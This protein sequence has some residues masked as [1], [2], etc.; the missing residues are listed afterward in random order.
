MVK[1]NNL[2]IIVIFIVYVFINNFF[3]NINLLITKSYEERVNKIYNVACGGFSYGFVKKVLDNYL[4]NNR[5]LYIH[6]FENFP[7]NYSLFLNIEFD[8]NIKNLILLNYKK[9]NTLPVHI[10][11]DNYLL[12]Y[13]LGNCYY[14]IKK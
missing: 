12:K 2:L 3:I 7:R 6:N 1:K 10:N 14:Y 9:E 5:K 11:L 13:N 4:S 8:Y